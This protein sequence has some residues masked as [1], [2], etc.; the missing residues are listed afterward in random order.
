MKE[1]FILWDFKTTFAIS[2]F[3]SRGQKTENNLAIF[4]PFLDLHEFFK[5]RRLSFENSDSN[6]RDSTSSFIWL[7]KFSIKKSKFQVL[8]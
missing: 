4:D 8:F 6:F 5:N 2:I 1:N 7:K 3:S